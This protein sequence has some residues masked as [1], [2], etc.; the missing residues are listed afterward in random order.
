VRIV[1]HPVTAII[2]AL[3]LSGSS[4]FGFSKDVRFGYGLLAAAGGVVVIAFVEWWRREGIRFQSPVTKASRAPKSSSK[5]LRPVT[6]QGFLDFEKQYLVATK[7]ATKTLEAVGRELTTNTPKIQA[8]AVSMQRV[9]GADVDRRLGAVNAAARLL[10]GHAARLENLEKTYRAQSRTIATN[11]V[12]MLE[13]TPLTSDLGEFPKAIATTGEQSS[14]AIASTAGYK[15]AVRG[16]RDMK[17]SQKV[18]QSAD[19]LIAVLDLLLEDIEAIVK[20]CN[21]ALAVIETRWPKP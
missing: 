9:K 7:A 20:A 6:E 15:E 13:T 11:L 16:T 8:A 2:V 5:V 21:D 19:R 12:D 3:A 14:D 18:N 17:V 10:N 1:G 4:V